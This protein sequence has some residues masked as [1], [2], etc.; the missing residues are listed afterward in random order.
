MF[1]VYD[2]WHFVVKR[3]E[4]KRGTVFQHLFYG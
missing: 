2:V 1:D 4:F 3:H